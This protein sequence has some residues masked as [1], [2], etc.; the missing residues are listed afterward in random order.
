MNIESFLVGAILIALC[1]LPFFLMSMHK[2]KRKNQKLK[3]LTNLANQNNCK[4]DKFELCGNYAIGVDKT[5][6]YVFFYKNN[7]EMN[8]T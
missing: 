2:R 7:K 4:I 6:K 8:N 1:S 5:K 3:I